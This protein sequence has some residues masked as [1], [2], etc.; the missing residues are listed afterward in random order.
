M[1]QRSRETKLKWLAIGLGVVL[2][3]L[4]QVV[5]FLVKTDM[6][7]GQAIPVFGDWFKILFI[8]NNGMAFGM[9]FGGTLGKFLLTAFRLVLIILLSYYIQ[10]LIKKETTPTGVIVGFTLIVVGALGNLI[11]SLFYGMLFSAST[12]TQVAQFL[13]KGG[14]Y[15]PFFYGKVVDML[16]FPIIDTTWPAWM[17][18][19]GGK[20][21]HF[22]D[23]I[24][25]IADSC[26]TI[27]AFYL[28][29]FQWKF[30]SHNTGE[31]KHEEIVKAEGTKSDKSTPA[32]RKR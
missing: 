7:V 2:V 18:G 30:F 26:I 10:K 29:I 32:Q 13:P 5:K 27:G 25:N 20:P 24:F 19:I 6:V 9:Q 21:F 12:T 14:G 8:E 17:P 23:A 15:A 4:D 16:Y 3:I 1:D 11:D 22:F 28:V 31:A